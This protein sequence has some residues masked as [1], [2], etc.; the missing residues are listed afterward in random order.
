MKMANADAPLLRSTEAT[1]AFF[2]PGIAIIGTRE[3]T[4]A[5]TQAGTY[6][7]EKFAEQGFNIVSGLAIPHR[8]TTGTRA[9]NVK[10]TTTAF[11]ANGLDY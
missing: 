6:F 10:G 3:P 8:H 2:T 5:A 1:S 11:L 7:A 4:E 9:L